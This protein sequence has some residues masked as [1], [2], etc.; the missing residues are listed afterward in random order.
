MSHQ[1]R[2]Q[3]VQKLLPELGCDALLIEDAINR[4]YLTGLNLS[5]GKVII[6]K[7]GAALLV[8][9]R[10]FELAKKSSPMEVVLAEQKT[11][12][13]MLKAWDFKLTTLSLEDSQVW[14]R[15]AD[16]FIS[17]GAIVFFTWLYSTT[18]GLAVQWFAQVSS[19]GTGYLA[20]RMMSCKSDRDAKKAGFKTINRNEIT[21]QD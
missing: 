8:D 19:D 20:Q 5:T 17:I 2:I 10:Y 14:A 13:E 3:K 7:A 4:F 1:N 18:G 11:L 15:S 9:S 6:D 21:S 16:N 12:E